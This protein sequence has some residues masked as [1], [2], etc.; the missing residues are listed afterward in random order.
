[1]EGATRDSHS[2]GWDGVKR[3]KV[4]QTWGVHVTRE[5]AGLDHEA[6]WT[7]DTHGTWASLASG[8]QQG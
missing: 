2:C 4:A 6:G 3:S 8:A 5:Q 1:M 7:P